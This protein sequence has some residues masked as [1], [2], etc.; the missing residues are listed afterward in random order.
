MHVNDYNK[1]IW[2]VKVDNKTWNW[3]SV[4]SVLSHMKYLMVKTLAA[5]VPSI[6]LELGFCSL[7]ISHT[8]CCPFFVRVPPITTMGAYSGSCPSFLRVLPIAGMGG[9]AGSCPSF[10]RVLPITGIGG[11][12]GRCTFG[13]RVLPITGM[14]GR[15]FRLR[16]LPMTGMGGHP[17]RLRVLP[18]TGMGGRPFR[19]RVLPITGMGGCP[20]RCPV[21]LRVLPVIITGRLPFF[22]LCFAGSSAC[23]ALVSCGHYAYCVRCKVQHN[24]VNWSTKSDLQTATLNSHLLYEVLNHVL[25]WT[26]VT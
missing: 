25:S 19:L 26:L 5:I 24:Y 7:Q 13:L 12:P 15:P 9:Y 6:P 2:N 8:S 23:P 17:F 10:L 20:G 4:A 1:Q 11:S 14:G 18:I 3:I 16:V 22:P 21:F